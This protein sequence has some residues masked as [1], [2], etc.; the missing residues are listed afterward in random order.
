MLSD[1]NGI[2]LEL[3]NKRNSRKYSSTWRLNITLVYDQWVIEEIRE[4]IKTFLGI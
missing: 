2:K 1:H 4:E 3:N